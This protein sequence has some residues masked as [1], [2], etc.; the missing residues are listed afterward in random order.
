MPLL[1]NDMFGCIHPKYHVLSG[2]THGFLELSPINILINRAGWTFKTTPTN[3]EKYQIQVNMTALQIS[4]VQK[5]NTS[6]DS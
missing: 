5:N 6:S 4:G 3:F 1:Q 2:V